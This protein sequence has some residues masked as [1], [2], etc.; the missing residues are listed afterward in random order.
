[1][2]LLLGRP[3]SCLA[4]PK[5]IS[6]DFRKGRTVALEFLGHFS[7]LSLTSTLISGGF[8]WMWQTWFVEWVFHLLFPI[9]SANPFSIGSLSL[10]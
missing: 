10:T 7:V 5:P 2:M 8:Q 3:E 6:V 1:M 9:F 4:N